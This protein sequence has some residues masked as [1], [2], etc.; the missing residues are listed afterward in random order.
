MPQYLSPGVYVEE[1][2]AGPV[3]IEGVSTSVTGAVGVTARGP[4][5]GKPQLVT[6]F[7]D[8]TRTFG[9]FLPE[10]AA[11]IVNQ[12]A[13]SADDG[14]RW[15]DFPLAVKGYFD[16][17][18]QQLFVKRVFSSTAVAA[19]KTLG[20]GIIAEITK[21]EPATSTTI[22]L[23]TLIG[24]ADGLV[25]QLFNGPTLVGPVTVQ[26]YDSATNIV[27]L[28]AALGTAVKAGV[29]YLVI[30][31]IVLPAAP[32]NETLKFS[33][34]ARGAWG[35]DVQV[36][37]RPVVG[38]TFNILQDPLIGGAIFVAQVTTQAAAGATNIA[39]DLAGLAVGDRVLINGHEYTVTAIGGGPDIT[40]GTAVPAGE[41][42]VVGT[43]VKRL[44]PANTPGP[45]QTLHIWGASRLYT[46]AIVEIDNGS[47][48][49]TTT[50]AS[51]SGEVVTFSNAL[52]NQYYEG[53]QLRVVEAE[54][55]VRYMPNGVV[56]TTEEFSPVR[57]FND[58]SSSYIVNNVNTLSQLVQVETRAG[59]S[60]SLL[61]AF[62]M[63]TTIPWDTLAAG[64]DALA[65]LKSD[66]FV[67]VDG[68]SGKRTGIQ[69]LEDI[70]EISI[71]T[72]PGIWA[73]SVQSAM[74]IHCETLKYRFAILD[75]KEDL[76]IEGIQAFRSPLD[77]KYAALYYPWLEV[78]DPSVS[79]NVTCPPSAHAAGIYAR[80]DVERGVHKAP[81]NETIRGIF[82]IRQDVTKREQDLLNPKGINA[83]RFFPG[84]G[85]RV[86]GA[87]TLSSDA[88]WKYINVRRLF[89]FIEASIDYGTQWVVFE[90]NDEPLWAR[91][92]ATITNFLGTQ[93]RN[94]ALQGATAAEA[95][96][97]KCD[98]TTMTQDD[99]DNGRLICLIGIAPVKPAEFVIF[100]IQQKTLEQKAP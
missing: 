40:I 2:N 93:W 89:I 35:N 91:V 60:D 15:W 23:R 96:F 26:S 22:K 41:T 80:V 30:Q 86:W 10:P 59:Y 32:A 76:S 11:S 57:L 65:N 87:R 18:G 62:P 95:F 1:K 68:G 73:A 16:N 69:A 82:K 19:S 4:T 85:N 28:T 3:P 53:E 27:T 52:A 47:A 77:T 45:G 8:F 42:W 66:D 14:G 50:V 9:D 17:G 25:F 34:S 46:G 63:V 67:G 49:E 24:V 64:D 55:S 37:V 72:V 56:T 54:V 81:A 92:R 21:D 29:S 99:I 48:K 58:N 44:R 74:I 39:V 98:R 84:R 13:L 5:T 12:W 70:P 6:S 33:A 75:P 100:Q 43:R 71:V 79:R 7:A 20:Q 83:L 94:G 61:S 36:R 97:V 78:R 88:S 31:P 51:V 38:A 90:P